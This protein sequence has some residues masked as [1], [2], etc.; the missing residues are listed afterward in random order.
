MVYELGLHGEIYYSWCMTELSLHG[1][2][3]VFMV[4]DLGL[5]DEKY[6]GGAT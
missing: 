5:H 1:E 3:L 2:I 4:Y 6:I